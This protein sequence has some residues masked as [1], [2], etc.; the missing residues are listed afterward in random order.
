MGYLAA[1][2]GLSRGLW[3]SDIILNI[4][5]KL[6]LLGPGKDQETANKRDQ[7][8]HDEPRKVLT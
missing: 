8:K 4:T 1:K 5:S 7:Q 2:E 3:E 6:P